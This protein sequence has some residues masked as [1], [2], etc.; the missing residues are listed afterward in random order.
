MSENQTRTWRLNNLGSLP[1]FVMHK[2]I[3]GSPPPLNTLVVAASSPVV[4]LGEVDVS[5]STESKVHFALKIYSFGTLGGQEPSWE[6]VLIASRRLVAGLW[7][8]EQLGALPQGTDSI[9]G[10]PSEGHCKTPQWISEK[11]VER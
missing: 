6:G 11:G 9:K 4:F 2:V 7:D 8:R 10:A 5:A 1:M 3:L